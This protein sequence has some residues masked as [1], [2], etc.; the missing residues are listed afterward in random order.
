MF[1]RRPVR[2]ALRRTKWTS[3]PNKFGKHWAFDLSPDSSQ[4]VSMYYN[5]GFEELHCQ[6]SIQTSKISLQYF[7]LIAS[8]CVPHSFLQ[9]TDRGPESWSTEFTFPW[10]AHGQWWL[11]QEFGS[12]APCLGV[13]QILP[14]N[15]SL[16]VFWG[17]DWGWDIIW[18][19][20]LPHFFHFC[21]V[22][23]LTY[24][25]LQGALPS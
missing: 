2:E 5:K 10:E 7:M 19:Y 21:L 6:C 17:W 12:L 1:H 25:L 15:V 8:L 23:C 22:S 20:T 11:G 16:R 4:F 13:G 14:S 24:C 9:R 3:W 18:N